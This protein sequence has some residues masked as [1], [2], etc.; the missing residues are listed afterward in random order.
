MYIRKNKLQRLLTLITR[1]KLT[2]AGHVMRKRNMETDLLMGSAFGRR[3]RGRPNTRF[4]DNI[5]E[6]LC[7]RGFVEI[8]RMPQG[9]TLWR[10][11]VAS[12]KS[13]VS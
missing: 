9:R 3:G 11:T 2:F 4:A 5:K 8:Y 13:S 12:Y 10:A 7:G 6:N 1:R